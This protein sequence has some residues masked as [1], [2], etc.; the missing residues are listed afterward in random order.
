MDIPVTKEE[1][2]LLERIAS[3][4]SEINVSSYLIGGFVRD[5]LIARGCKDIDVVCIGNG[6]ELAHAVAASL[7][8]VPKVSY[9]KNFGTAH[10]NWKGF[11][12]EFVGARRESYQSHSRKP[13]VTPVCS[14]FSINTWPLTTVI[15]IPLASCLR[16]LEPPGP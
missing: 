16:R 6:I 12:V 15:S 8:P 11:D 3:V 10:F 1:S 9:F 13:E 2:N 7:H 14:P 4:S 5:R